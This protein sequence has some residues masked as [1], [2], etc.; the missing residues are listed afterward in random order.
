MAAH[1][2]LVACRESLGAP[3]RPL[4]L[5]IEGF[6]A[7]AAH[8]AARLAPG[9]FAITA[10]STL[11][12]AV[13]SHRGFAP[14]ELIESRR[15]FGDAFVAHVD[16]ARLAPEALLAADVDVLVPSARTWSISAQ[17]AGSV[18]A[19]LIAPLANAPY[20]DGAV[21]ALE[22][23]GIRCLPGFVVNCGGVFAS[24]LSD[25]GVP[26]PQIERLCRRRFR[27]VVESLLRAAGHRAESPVR[28]AEEVALR[29]LAARTAG[30][31]P[32]TRGRRLARALWSEGVPRRLRAP[33]IL[34]RFERNL[35][36][37]NGV[38][39]EYGRTRR[40]VSAGSPG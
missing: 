31:P 6:G 8:L 29:R 36:E 5:A 21:E 4:R 17:R 12:G 25:S 22:A 39:T 34:R 40:E 37:L 30:L 10:V 26:L 1:Q 18:R 20:G 16:G 15:R 19:R 9:D 7:V 32:E 23:R 33:A 24:S 2:A 28:V 35:V 11:D 14:V 27:P 13:L 38:L 3:A